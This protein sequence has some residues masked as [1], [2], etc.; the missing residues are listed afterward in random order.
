MQIEKSRFTSLK[1]CIEFG[2]STNYITDK[3]TP[4]MICA[5]VNENLLI[6]YNIHNR[7]MLTKYQFDESI[8]LLKIHWNCQSDTLFLIYKNDYLK[9]IPNAIN[10]ALKKS[11]N[12]TDSIK[13]VTEILSIECYDIHP[14][15][16]YLYVFGSALQNRI[17]IFQDGS[18]RKTLTNK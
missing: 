8:N 10:F 2:P 16:M 17:Y 7:Q 14:R 18:N 11:I 12:I 4:E 13:T 5:T 9:F 1:F 6:I 3:D 15:D